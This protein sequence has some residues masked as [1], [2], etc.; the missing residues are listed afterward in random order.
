MVR[1]SRSVLAA[2]VA[3]PVMGSTPGRR[4]RRAR[5]RARRR[6]KDRE[7]IGSLGVAP[8]RASR[9]PLRG[10]SLVRAPMMS[11]GVV[12]GLPIGSIVNPMNHLTE[13]GARPSSWANLKDTLGTT[14]TGKGFVMKYAHPCSEEVPLVS[15]IPDHVSEAVTTPEFR[16]DTVVG[17]IGTTTGNDDIEFIVPPFP[18]YPI[19]YRRYAA[20]SPPA[21]RYE[22]WRYVTSPT[23]NTRSTYRELPRIAGARPTE[24]VVPLTIGV[25]TSSYVDY[26]ARSRGMYSGATFHLDA[27]ALSDQGRVVAG[28]MAL[29]Y[30]KQDS[31]LAHA[32]GWN[33]DGTVNNDAQGVIPHINLASLPLTESTLV[34]TCLGAGV[35][36]ARDGIY[37]TMRYRDPVHLFVSTNDSPVV[38]GIGSNNSGVGTTSIPDMMR[39]TEPGFSVLPPTGAIG[40]L[41]EYGLS[42]ACV[43]NFNTGVVL[44]KGISGTANVQVKS[45]CGFENLVVAGNAVSPY[46]HASPSLDRLAIDRATE[47]AQQAPMVYPASYNDLS[48]IL[49]VIKDVVNTVGTPLR[50]I[51]N[52]IG[53]LGIPVVSDIANIG[54]GLLGGLGYAPRARAKTAVQRTRNGYLR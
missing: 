52:V 16:T 8:S 6:L 53:G 36:E 39:F 40:T 49:N 33:A 46:Q 23:V 13:G 35:W 42:P 10:P 20:S 19:L 31:T 25:K 34:Q 29:P 3:A 50:Q 24:T 22:G 7:L 32:N 48:S 38:L 5:Y 54:A 1:R 21:T 37:M 14:E 9:G 41:V 28:Q 2:R 17:P 43:T 15:G 27:P 30:D 18:E 44:F 11:D 47:I 12:D 4:R 26:Y 51:G 45:V